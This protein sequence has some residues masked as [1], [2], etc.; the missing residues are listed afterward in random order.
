MQLVK[1][2]SSLK[3]RTVVIKK[4]RKLGLHRMAE[5]RK[6]DLTNQYCIDVFTHFIAPYYSAATQTGVTERKLTNHSAGHEQ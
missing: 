6:S 5:E 3:K 4:K 2:M 1:I